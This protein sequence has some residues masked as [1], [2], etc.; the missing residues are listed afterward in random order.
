MAGEEITNSFNE[1]LLHWLN[2]DIMT[3]EERTN[4]EIKNKPVFGENDNRAEAITAEQSLKRIAE[5]EKVHPDFKAIAE[6][7]WA[8]TENIEKCTKQR[9][10]G[11]WYIFLKNIN[12]N[13]AMAVFKRAMVSSFPITSIISV[14]PPGVTAIP[15]AAIRRHHI[16]VPDF[17]ANFSERATR[18]V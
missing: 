15:E 1:Y 7:V 18:Q 9:T 5:L 13:F 10:F 16:S 2:T 11:A 12:Q 6:K 4:G 17:I 3:L 8:Y 14:A